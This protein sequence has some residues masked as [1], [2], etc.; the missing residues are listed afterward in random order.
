MLWQQMGRG[1]K[2][3]YKSQ[4]RCLRIKFFDKHLSVFALKIA[5]PVNTYMDFSRINH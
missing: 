1:F 5:D 3:F 2:F 4:F